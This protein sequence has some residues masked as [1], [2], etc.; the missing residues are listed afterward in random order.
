MA[1]IVS[2]SM[3]CHSTSSSSLHSSIVVDT[4]CNNIH[5]YTLII[6][7][8]YIVVTMQPHRT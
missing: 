8:F 3:H 7:I 1:P 5:I 6:N 4:T 2:S